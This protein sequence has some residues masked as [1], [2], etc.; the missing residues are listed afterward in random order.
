[1]F[2]RQAMLEQ[3][4]PLMKRLNFS[5]EDLRA[6][7]EGRL[8]RAQLRR[9]K[10]IR[11]LRIMILVGA[12]MMTPLLFSPFIERAVGVMIGAVGLDS[13]SLWGNLL[14]AL[15]AL[16]FI[17]WAADALAKVNHDLNDAR[18][19]TVEGPAQL[20]SARGHFVV[21]TQRFYLQRRVFDFLTHNQPY[22]VYYIPRAGILLGLESLGD[23]A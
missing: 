1:M 21:G 15:M 4:T 8:S 9:L 13:M 22:R 7:R 18:V 3:P 12:L 10:L 16:A 6:N 11:V 20:D 23:I 17:V 2:R 19:S 14:I 5:H